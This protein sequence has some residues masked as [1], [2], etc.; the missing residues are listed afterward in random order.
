MDKSEG[1]ELL[2]PAADQPIAGTRSDVRL[3]VGVA[4]RHCAARRGVYDISPRRDSPSRIVTSD[5]GKRGAGYAEVY[6]A[7]EVVFC[8]R[9]FGVR[10]AHPY[11]GSAF[12]K[13]ET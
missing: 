5:H 2:K 9:L 8:R 6:D 12:T 1:V 10:E 11:G 13:R 7:R 4:P 3:L